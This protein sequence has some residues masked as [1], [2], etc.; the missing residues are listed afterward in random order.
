MTQTR[1]NFCAQ[2]GTSVDDSMRASQRLGRHKP[3][4]RID[5]LHFHRD[6][7][8]RRWLYGP[9]HPNKGAITLIWSFLYQNPNVTRGDAIKALTARGLNK[10]TI[11]TQYQKWRHASDDERRTRAGL[12]SPQSVNP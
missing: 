8:A 7:T 10:G 11:S 3:L 9:S 12:W 6:E 1:E 5:T 2:Q 4:D